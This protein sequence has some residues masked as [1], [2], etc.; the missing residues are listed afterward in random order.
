M[1][2]GE[3][4]TP[5]CLPEAFPLYEIHCTLVQTPL[6]RHVLMFGFQLSYTANMKQ[7]YEHLW[8]CLKRASFRFF[9]S[10]FCSNVFHKRKRWAV[11]KEPA[12]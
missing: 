5:F 8:L 6:H 9:L 11:A 10:P 2:E 3:N 12:V 7:D 1:Y 4:T